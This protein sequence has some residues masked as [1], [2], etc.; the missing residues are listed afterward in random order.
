ME[1]VE[2]PSPR[3]S[4]RLSRR[5]SREISTWEKYFPSSVE[6]SD[7]F[8]RPKTPPPPALPSSESPPAATPAESEAAAGSVQAVSSEASSELS[9]NLLEDEFV[10]DDELFTLLPDLPAPP[11]PAVARHS[12][13]PAALSPERTKPD[14]LS[15]GGS[16][17][18]ATLSEHN[19][20]RNVYID[21]LIDN[22][23][24]DEMDENLPVIDSMEMNVGETQTLSNENTKRKDKIDEENVPA[25]SM[26]MNVGESQTPSNESTEL[27]D[28]N[29]EE[30]I[31]VDS[32]EV[33]VGETKTLS[34][35]NTDKKDNTDTALETEKDQS[36]I[37]SED[38][39]ET[40]T[41]SAEKDTAKEIFVSSSNTAEKNIGKENPRE[42][43]LDTREEQPEG[44][45][46]GGPSYR[47]SLAVTC[48]PSCSDLPRRDCASLLTVAPGKDS[49]SASLSL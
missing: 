40:S 1:S 34:N 27:N 12:E 2:L 5:K 3:L 32:L 22:F 46:G 47:S 35:E 14:S 39:F 45:E 49:L 11:P 19:Y 24:L 8:S 20:S 23:A 41:D 42:E 38:I 16:E 43:N 31:Q 21:E 15:S 28:E 44:P 7:K 30:N 29:G 9:A 25:D 37:E 10:K 48:H 13:L 26:E 33:N 18:R 4:T 6:A 36:A 17:C